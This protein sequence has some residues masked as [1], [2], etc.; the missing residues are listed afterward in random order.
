MKAFG[1]IVLVILALVLL[2]FI[3]K[4]CQVAEKVTNV[5]TAFI[6]YEQFQEMWNTCQKI[7][8]D[9]GIIKDVPEDDKQFE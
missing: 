1:I 4:G 6:N 8:T 3:G 9:L 5:D 7:N 2:W